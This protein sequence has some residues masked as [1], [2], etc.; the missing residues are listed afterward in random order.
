M[1]YYATPFYAV[2]CYILLSYFPLIFMISCHI[3]LS[4]F[5]RLMALDQSNEWGH[6]ISLQEISYELPG[7]ETTNSSDEKKSG[8]ISDGIENQK[9]NSDSVDHDKDKDNND[10]SS[11]SSSSSSGSTDGSAMSTSTGTVG[12]V[13]I[14]YMLAVFKRL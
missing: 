6:F 4:I 3:Y 11:S 9:D 2:L 12:T 5:F 1:L 10:S 14:N 7:V 8:D 13:K